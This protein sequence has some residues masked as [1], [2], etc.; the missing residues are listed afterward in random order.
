MVDE[1]KQRG[2]MTFIF[3]NQAIMLERMGSR[4][5]TLDVIFDTLDDLALSGNYQELDD[6]LSKLDV[7]DLSELICSGI[8]SVT[9]PVAEHL[10]SRIRFQDESAILWPDA[11]W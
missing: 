5:E 2:N 3:I 7:C 10:P 1:I 8:L 11:V 4:S 6:I 9:R